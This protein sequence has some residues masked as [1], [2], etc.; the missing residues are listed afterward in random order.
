LVTS[1]DSGYEETI[2]R[3]AQD[4]DALTALRARLRN[5][6]G[7]S[8]LFDA[9]RYTRN[10]ENGLRAAHDHFATGKAAEHIWVLDPKP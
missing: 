2:L 7:S 6:I 3:L 9:R 8:L 4:P 5:A 1:T 10:F